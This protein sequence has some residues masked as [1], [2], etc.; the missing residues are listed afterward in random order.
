MSHAFSAALRKFRTALVLFAVV[1]GVASALILNPSSALANADDD[2]RAER[3]ERLANDMPVP[4]DDPAAV[5]SGKGRFGERCGY[6]HGGG[7]RGAKGPCL[8]CGHFKRGGKSS[9]IYTNIAV[10]VMGTQMGAFGTSLSSEEI[11]NI[12]G[13]LRSETRRRDASGEN[14]PH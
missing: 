14:A 1:L 9:A 7:G 8:V 12:V 5:E 3:A 13:Y 6:C 11:L 10:G 2:E 4:M